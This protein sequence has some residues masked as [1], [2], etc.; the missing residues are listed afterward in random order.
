LAGG[1]SVLVKD[2]KAS[3]NWPDGT[4]V[5]V[6]GVLGA[7]LRLPPSRA[8]KVEG[9]LGNDDGDYKNDLKIRGQ[10]AQFPPPP[11]YDQFHASWRIPLSSSEALFL[12]GP[13][14][15]NPNYPARVLS[16][17]DFPASVVLAAYQSCQQAGVRDQWA[18]EA[19]A[20]DTAVTG[21]ASWAQ[22]V[23]QFDPAQIRVLIT[24]TLAF[25]GPGQA[26]TFVAL[27]E[28]SAG[29][30]VTWSASAGS[31]APN[32]LTVTYTAP[33]EPGEYTVTA[34][35]VGDPTKSS[36]STIVVAQATGPLS[37]FFVGSY[38]FGSMTMAITHFGSA[39]SAVVSD[40]IDCKYDAVGS[41]N[42][43]V[44]TLD[45]WR[46]RATPACREINV[47]LTGTVSSDYN[48]I[49]GTGSTNGTP[50]NFS[51]TRSA[52]SMRQSS[53]RVGGRMPKR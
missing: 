44:L 48:Q 38:T 12:E 10:A 52:A 27:V 22:S 4:S 11:L 18:L 3:I 17:S 1:G 41:L 42:G 26:R 40:A 2:Q 34:T 30:A 9:L 47:T 5:T 43:N 8:G 35:A 21:D 20:F 51:V 16:L 24:P 25:L 46:V 39:V 6:T 19:C 13:D 53:S 37:G 36:T 49:T 15:W 23:E 14:Y 28:G 33:S 7:T 31:I 45:N 29:G 32:G 50:W